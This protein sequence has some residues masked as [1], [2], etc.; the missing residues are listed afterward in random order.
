MN[1]DYGSRSEGKGGYSL[2]KNQR[3]GQTGDR[4]SRER[5]I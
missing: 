5:Q 1:G 3:A 2:Q 4:A